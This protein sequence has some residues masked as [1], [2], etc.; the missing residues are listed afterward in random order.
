MC[1]QIGVVSSVLL[2]IGPGATIFRVLATGNT[3]PGR[4]CH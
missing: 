3:S 4:V 1:G 2:S